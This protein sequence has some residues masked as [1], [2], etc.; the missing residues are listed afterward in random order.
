MS[1]SLHCGDRLAALCRTDAAHAR[2]VMSMQIQAAITCSLCNHQTTKTMPTDMPT[3]IIPL[4]TA[5][6][7]GLAGLVSRRWLLRYPIQREI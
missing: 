3:E 5:M 1:A 4:V 6:N 7:D 2:A